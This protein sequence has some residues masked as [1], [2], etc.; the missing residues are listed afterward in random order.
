MP[1]PGDPRSERLVR[2][3]DSSPS[4][5]N[6]H[7]IIT[8]NFS[9]LNMLGAPIINSD[10]VVPDRLSLTWRS[11]GLSYPI[12]SLRRCAVPSPGLRC[13][14]VRSLELA[15]WCC[16]CEGSSLPV[17]APFPKEGF[18]YQSYSGANVH[19]T[20]NGSNFYFLLQSYQE[21]AL[22]RSQQIN[23]YPESFQPPAR[24]CRAFRSA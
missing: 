4:E 24:N 6:S 18:L 11:S 5:Y 3:R 10:W 1:A 2:C 19:I 22:A 14:R 17:A 21:L 13:E 15:K 16:A 7:I 20:I 8:R 12:A 9:S 23:R